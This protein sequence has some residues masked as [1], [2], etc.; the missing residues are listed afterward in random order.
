[1]SSTAVTSGIVFVL[2]GAQ[3]STTVSL[4]HTTVGAISRRRGSSVATARIN[5]HRNPDE[6]TVSHI[7]AQEYVIEHRVRIRQRF[8]GKHPIIN[9]IDDGNGVGGVWGDF[10]VD[11]RNQVL[12]K[13]QL[14]NVR[15]VPARVS[16]VG[17]CV[18][19]DV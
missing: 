14:S 13:E 18:A 7:V 17:E 12:I 8:F 10:R 11:L 1:M 3:F 15:N 6:E 16:A 9:V 2:A 5:T 19:S 4:K